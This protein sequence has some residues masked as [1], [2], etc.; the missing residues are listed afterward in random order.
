MKK[1][2][3]LLVFLFCFTLQGQEVP[4]ITTDSL[5]EA[6]KNMFKTNLVPLLW[7]TGSLSYERK[8]IGRLVVGATVNYRPESEVPFKKTLQKIVENEDKEEATF[9][10]DQ[11]KY[12]N[13]S[14]APEIK[15]YLGKKGAFN[16]FYVAAFVKTEKTKLDYSYQFD[17]LLL[18]GE[19]PNF[20]IKG[21]VKALS[22]GLYF[23]VQWSLGKNLYLDWQIIGGNYGSGTINLT[24]HRHLTE[25]EQME[26][27]EFAQDLKD[28]FK[29][30]DY[31]IND[32]GIKVK[33]KIPWA[34]LRTGL[35][36][37]YRF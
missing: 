1:G 11:L 19:D 27:Q 12:S 22:G 29:N 7:G 9:N 33:G 24:A 35:S 2:V 36:I 5:R 28:S 15:I 8:A 32:N 6:K 18:V 37:G 30:L 25:D 34:G 4:Q 23:G 13:F 10:V 3:V 16:G 21:E 17:E 31:E 20:P 26:L 14:L